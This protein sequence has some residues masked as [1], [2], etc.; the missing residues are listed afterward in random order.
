VIQHTNDEAAHTLPLPEHAASAC[1]ACATHVSCAQASMLPAA[2]H[3][4]SC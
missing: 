4:C 3:P 1:T 2:C